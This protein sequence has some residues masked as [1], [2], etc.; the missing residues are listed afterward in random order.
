MIQT[1]VRRGYDSD[2]IKA[3]KAKQDQN[4]VSVVFKLIPV[5]FV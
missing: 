3:W 1:L 5:S 2:P 4:V